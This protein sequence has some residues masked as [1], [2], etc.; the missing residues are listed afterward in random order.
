M[1]WTTYYCIPIN[2]K[3]QVLPPMIDQ[4]SGGNKQFHRTVRNRLKFWYRHLIVG[5]NPSC[6][7][8]TSRQ[9][10]VDT[11]VKIYQ[12]ER[13]KI[14]RH[15]S[16]KQFVQFSLVY[17][18]ASLWASD[19][20]NSNWAFSSYNMARKLNLMRWRPLWFRSTRICRYL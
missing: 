20:Y 15:L 18:V 19:C 3:K 12:N 7:L 2:C 4:L 13:D 5:L 16:T 6:M 11:Y 1:K 17:L 8:R 10:N 14:K 9:S